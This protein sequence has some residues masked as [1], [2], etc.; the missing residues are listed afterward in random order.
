MVS[1]SKK[2]ILGVTGSIAAYKAADLVR[3]LQENDLDVTVIMTQEAQKFVTPL[4]F[5]SL[6]GNKVFGVEGDVDDWQMP[7]IQLAK[8]AD[9][10]I[11]APATANIIAKMANGIADDIVS[12]TVLSSKADVFI[13]P[14]MNV[15]MYQNTLTQKNCQKLKECGFIFIEPVE[16]KL[17]C[18]DFG[19]GHLADLEDIV[20]VVLKKLG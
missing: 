18:G 5:A 8:K 16:G 13:A 12:A 11:I 7:H 4:T 10:I 6:S 9:A 1:L 20:K 2:I 14:A 17:A 3:L 19:Q 15:E